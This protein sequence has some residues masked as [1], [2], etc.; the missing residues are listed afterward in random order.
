MIFPFIASSHSRRAMP[1]G[2]PNR[3]RTSA[4]AAAGSRPRKSSRCALQARWSASSSPMFW[5]KPGG[6]SSRGGGKPA[7]RA[8]RKSIRS[9]VDVI[10]PVYSADAGLGDPSFF[11]ALRTAWASSSGIGI[12]HSFF[13]SGRTSNRQRIC[14]QKF[15]ATTPSSSLF[16]Y[17][18]GNR[19]MVAVSREPGC[20]RERRVRTRCWSSNAREPRTS[21]REAGS[22]CERG[23]SQDDQPLELMIAAFEL[24]EV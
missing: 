14:F 13:R 11:S 12:F 21:H 9:S 2:S 18:I 15:F 7:E 4:R 19:G 23:R 10:A 8:W 5:R 1:A 6:S 3:L 20:S 17:S 22:L 16:E 24:D